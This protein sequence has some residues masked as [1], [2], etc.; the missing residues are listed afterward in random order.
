[1]NTV[2]YNTNYRF[3]RFTLKHLENYTLHGNLFGIYLNKI[4]DDTETYTYIV[5]MFPSRN[6][7]VLRMDKRTLTV[8]KLY[9][10]LYPLIFRLNIKWDILKIIVDQST[11]DA[12]IIDSIVNFYDCP[13]KMTEMLLS[14]GYQYATDGNDYIVYDISIL[15]IVDS[16][17]DNLFESENNRAKSKAQRRLFAMALAYKNGKLPEKYASDIVKKLS[18]TVKE[19]TLRGFASTNQKKRKKD[20]SIS[21]RNNIPYHV[22]KK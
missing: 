7:K 6:C 20:G 2:Y 22:N 21:K 11:S 12:E 3:T 15:R 9:D 19:D 1:M 18:K 13:I 4:P 14:T 10:I 16:I 5:E 17:N 8:N